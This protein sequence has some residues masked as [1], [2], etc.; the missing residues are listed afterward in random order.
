MFQSKYTGIYHK[1]KVNANTKR[2]EIW[3]IKSEWVY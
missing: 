1:T 3:D 2:S